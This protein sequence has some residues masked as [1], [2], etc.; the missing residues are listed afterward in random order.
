MLSDFQFSLTAIFLSQ[1]FLFPQETKQSFSY[2]TLQ[3]PCAAFPAQ[4][5]QFMAA[6]PAFCYNPQGK[7][8][9]NV[10]KTENF[11][12]NSSTY[13][14]KSWMT[15]TAENLVKTK[16]N[17]HVTLVLFLHWKVNLKRRNWLTNTEDG[18]SV[19]QDHPF[20]QATHTSRG[21]KHTEKGHHQILLDRTYCHLRVN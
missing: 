12:P 18:L 7:V 20:I 4:E 21:E 11:M 1:W 6:F 9:D 14:S 19:C 13:L 17:C 8:I 10:R 15:Q 16:V 2:T 3:Q 5:S